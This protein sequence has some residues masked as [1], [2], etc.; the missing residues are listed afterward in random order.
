M[1]EILTSEDYKKL[2]R[3]NMALMDSKLHD[4]EYYVLN[5]LHN[6][7]DFEHSMFL[8]FTDNG[9][10][11]NIVGY[12]IEN[13]MI[14]EYA[15]YFYKKDLVLEY[16]NKNNLSSGQRVVLLTDIYNEG[17]YKNIEYCDF[18]EKNGLYWNMSLVINDNGDGIRLL[19]KYEK[20][21][22]KPRERELAVHLCKIFNFQYKIIME[23][24]RLKYEVDLFNRS[25]EN[26]HFG[27]LI[28]D[29][30]FNLINFNK[31]SLKYM[32]DIT[33][34]YVLDDIISEFKDIITNELNNKTTVINE[35]SIFKYITSYIIEIIPSGEIEDNNL[36]KTY[37]MVYIYDKNWFKKI[38]TISMHEI[39]N[40]YNL[41]EREQ[42][43]LLLITKGLSNK[44]I[45]NQLSVSIYTIKEHI[46]N[47]FKKMDGNSRTEIISKIYS[48]F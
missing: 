15:D 40:E 6:I 32:Y 48:N 26:M 20:G 24:R 18:I 8:S 17:G 35:T 9:D 13:T 11:Q 4:F 43:I 14:N 30:D 19:R 12:N 27:Y 31:K 10:L 5:L 34:K 41:T 45:A 29:S 7:F 42:E 2:S 25:K 46:K 1:A 36:M 21:N 33:G 39:I 37:Y 47:I 28:F 23:N 38:S 44:A 3:F 16:L 22:F